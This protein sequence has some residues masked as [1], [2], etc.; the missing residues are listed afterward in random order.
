[1]LRA[2]PTTSAPVYASTES[3]KDSARQTVS[4]KE[5]GGVKLWDLDAPHLYTVH[6]RLLQ[7]GK[8]IDEDTRRIG[9]REAVFTDH[10]FSLNGKVVKLRGLDRHQT[11][12]YVGQASRR[13][14]SV[15]TQ[16]FCATTALQHSC[17]RRTTH[18]PGTS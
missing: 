8:V 16:R 4:L 14:C 2:D 6:V 11:F 17:G 7:G 18:N 3:V 12:P 15:R 9:F 13:E 1:M 5:L 10:G